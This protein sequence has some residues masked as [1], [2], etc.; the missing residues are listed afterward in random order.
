MCAFGVLW[1]SCEAPAAR[2]GGAAGVP[3]DNQR[4][5]TCPG[6]Q[7]HH[8]NSTRR[9][10]RE[11]RK[12]E[13]SGGRE[14]KKE[15]NF[16]RSRGRAVRGRGPKILNTPT[17]HT[18]TTTTNK[19]HQ[20]APTGNNQ[21]QQQAPTGNNQEQ[22]QQPGTTTTEN[23]AKTLKHQNWPNAVWPNAVNTLKHQNWP[24]AVWPNAVTKTNWPNSDL[25]GQMRFWPNAVW[26]NA[27]MTVMGWWGL[28]ALLFCV[29]FFFFFSVY[30]SV[31]LSVFLSVFVLMLWFVARCPLDGYYQCWRLSSPVPS[32]VCRDLLDLFALAYPTVG[33]KHFRCTEVLFMPVSLLRER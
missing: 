21:E 26:P 13:I 9:P 1:L 8:Q 27:G 17:T 11:R 23:L 19:H 33:A 18:Q 5:Q 3:H 31:F 15:R 6:L 2:S 4:A 32:G 22:Q 29:F 7:K 16:V 30:F 12:K 14:K 20:Q 28:S 10:P 25:F 24:N